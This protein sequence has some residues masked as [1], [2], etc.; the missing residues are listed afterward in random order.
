M[1]SEKSNLAG[2]TGLLSKGVVPPEIRLG[3]AADRL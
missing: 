3:Q 2:E 1:L